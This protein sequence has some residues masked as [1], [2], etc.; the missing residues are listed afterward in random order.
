LRIDHDEEGYD[1]RYDVETLD[2][3]FQAA[4]DRHLDR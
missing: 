1:V 4:F 3:F 2:E